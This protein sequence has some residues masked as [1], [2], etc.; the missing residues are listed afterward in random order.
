MI[1]STGFFFFCIGALGL[2]IWMMCEID[3]HELTIPHFLE[4]SST[5]LIIGFFL[6]VLSMTIQIYREGAMP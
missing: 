2:C 6:M 1:L 3:D 5:T 4:A